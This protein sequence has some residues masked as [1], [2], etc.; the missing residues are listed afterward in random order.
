[1]KSAIEHHLNK[2]YSGFIQ[3]PIFER[4]R[5]HGIIAFPDAMSYLKVNSNF[6]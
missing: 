1:M 6:I 5:G 4:T 3:N 2:R